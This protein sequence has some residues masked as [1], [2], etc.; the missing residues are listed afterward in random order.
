MHW[1]TNDGSWLSTTPGKDASGEQ[2]LVAV[3]GTLLSTATDEF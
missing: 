3:S 1:W 2:S